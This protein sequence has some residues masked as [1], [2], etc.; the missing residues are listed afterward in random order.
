MGLM[1][2]EGTQ[3]SLL[4]DAHEVF[5][6]HRPKPAKSEVCV[7]GVKYSRNI[8]VENDPF[9]QLMPDAPNYLPKSVVMVPSA[10]S[11]QNK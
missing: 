1:N 2:E 11:P 8:M 6:R 3:L 5:Q 9:C 4:K 7:I 10:P